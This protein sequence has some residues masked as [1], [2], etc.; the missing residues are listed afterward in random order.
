MMLVVKTHSSQQGKLICITDASLIGKKFEDEKKQL[1]L[2]SN[3]YKGE[4]KS[5]EIIEKMLTSSYLAI[6][7]GKESIEF[8]KKLGI[9]D[10]DSVLDIC[11]IPHTQCLIG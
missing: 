8:G 10:D 4:Q 2:S 11:G 6:F 9:I 5:P 1:D 7:S 3:F